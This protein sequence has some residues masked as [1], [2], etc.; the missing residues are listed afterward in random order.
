MGHLKGTTLFCRRWGCFFFF[1]AAAALSRF[2]RPF[3]R[4]WVIAWAIDRVDAVRP[5][6][7]ARGQKWSEVDQV[8]PSKQDRLETLRSSNQ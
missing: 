4:S 8:F 6:D 2:F 5:H 3:F 7:P 1:W